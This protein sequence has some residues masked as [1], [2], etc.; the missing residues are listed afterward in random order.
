MVVNNGFVYVENVFVGGKFKMGR[1]G[2]VLFF[3][4]FYVGNV[5]IVFLFE[6]IWLN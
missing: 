2:F 3:V 6:F 4:C 1:F 5:V